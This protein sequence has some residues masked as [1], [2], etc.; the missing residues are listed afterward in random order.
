MINL[1]IYSVKSAYLW[2]WDIF[3]YI[4]GETPQLI[5]GRNHYYHTEKNSEASLFHRE[6]DFP[7]KL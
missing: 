2:D 1:S 7:K 4:E 6:I 5:L 3:F